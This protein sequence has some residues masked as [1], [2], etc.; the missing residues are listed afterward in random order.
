MA[1]VDYPEPVKALIVHLKQLP[2]IGPKSAERVAVWMMQQKKG[3][4]AL[5][6][7]VVRVA[8]ET[9]FEYPMKAIFTPAAQQGQQ[10]E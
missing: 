3:T 1:Q 5:F 10:E 7:D 9:V 4:T 2:G 6:S 8:G